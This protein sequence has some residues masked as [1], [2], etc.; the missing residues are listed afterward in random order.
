MAKDTFLLE[1]VT[2]Y[3]QLVREEV[4]E[5]TAPGAEGEFGVLGGHTPFLT[6]LGVGELMYRIGSEEHFLAVRRGFAEV[7]HAKVTV[8]AEEAEFPAEIDLQ[9]AEALK[10]EAEH[11]LQTYSREAKEY[12][13]AEAKMERAMNQLQV[14]GRRR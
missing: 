2:P 13:E 8:L 4:A 7:Q 1:V 5:I 14:G 9:A 6:A 12:L 3:R 10:A 11:E